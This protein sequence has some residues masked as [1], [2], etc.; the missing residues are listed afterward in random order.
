MSDAKRLAQL[1]ARFRERPRKRARKT[2]SEAAKQEAAKRVA[3]RIEAV[4]K[5]RAALKQ[6]EEILA[7][8]VGESRARKD[9]RSL[10][11][12]LVEELW[13][14]RHARSEIKGKPAPRLQ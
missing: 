7:T 5:A 4:R 11:D 1:R 14:L 10:R 6:V 8:G 9:L 3:R 13:G 2:R 12:E